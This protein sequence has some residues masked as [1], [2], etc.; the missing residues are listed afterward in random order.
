MFASAK[1]FGVAYLSAFTRVKS[2]IK[3]QR[4]QVFSIIQTVQGEVSG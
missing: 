3:F 4:M 1:K 2:N